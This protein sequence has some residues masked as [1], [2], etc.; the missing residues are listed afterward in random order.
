MFRTMIRSGPGEE[1]IGLDAET[2]KKERPFSSSVQAL[3]LAVALGM[4]NDAKMEVQGE[5]AQLL[6]LEL[7]KSS[8]NFNP[9]RQLIRSKFDIKD[10]RGMIDMMVQFAEAGVR[11]LY[12]MYQK[13]G[14]IDF[15][16]L[17]Q[18]VEQ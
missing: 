11:E 9:F 3:Y 18:R 8:K 4:I 14:K 16:K 12:D 13:T 6:R 10:D 17:S 7:L 5:K 1:G 15:Y 2:D